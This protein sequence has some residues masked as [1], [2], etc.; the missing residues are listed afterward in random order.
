MM[1]A[2]WVL[3]L[4]GLPGTAFAGGF[5]VPTIG[6][7][8]S[9]RT[10][11]TAVADDTTAM[12]HNPAGLV[13][14]DGYQLDISVTG[15]YSHTVYQL[16]DIVDDANGNPQVVHS[17]PVYLEQPFGFLPYFGFA[18]DFGLEDW[19]F[20][21]AF[22]SP[23]NAATSLDE[24][25]PTNFQLI[26]GAVIT[27]HLTPTVAWR[28]NDKLA[29][30][31][32]VSVVY[33]TVELERLRDM[34]DVLPIQSLV[35][36]LDLDGEG[37]SASWDIGLLY[38]PTPRLTLG[39]AYLSQIK[40]PFEGEITFSTDADFLPTT[41]PDTGGVADATS[42]FTFPR[43]LRFG[44]DYEIDEQWSIGADLAWYDYSVFEDITIEVENIQATLFGNPLDLSDLGGIEIVEPKNSFDIY[45]FTF[46]AT[47]KP[48]ERWEFMGGV[49]YDESPYPNNTYT[50][51]SPDA[52]KF[53][54]SIGGGY[55]AESG[56]RLNL[57]YTR[58][59]YEDRIVT[60][61][62]LTPPANGRVLGKFTNIVGLQVGYRF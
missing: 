22:Y 12:Y 48:S 51:L 52:D 16:S 7:R 26:E 44:I 28:M 43:I 24:R 33:G 41:I 21:I 46:G 32:G 13:Q 9:A 45:T 6:G 30:G 37:W 3:L 15:I 42:T 8:M 1:R 20:G 2:F 57:S 17:D 23:N 29:F 56:V 35:A 14:V 38:N 58:L 40:V 18:G 11:F 10:A 27:A 50:I 36:L 59:V 55:H 5:N 60:N 49:L 53:G 31:A 54:V 62:I 39:L 34:N 25:A 4:A 19:R 47:F 61:S